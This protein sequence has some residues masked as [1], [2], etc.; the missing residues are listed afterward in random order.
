MALFA[1]VIFGEKMWSKG[2]WVARAAGA[3]L[4]AAGLLSVA[5]VIAIVPAH[6]PAAMSMPNEMAMPQM[7]EN[8]SGEANTEGGMADEMPDN[9]P[10]DKPS[11]GGMAM[12]EGSGGMMQQR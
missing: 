6:D 5:G 4:A 1:G 9:S 10:D 12:G 7:S 2:V 11:P 8:M 3:G